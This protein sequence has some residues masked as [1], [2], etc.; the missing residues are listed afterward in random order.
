MEKAAQVVSRRVGAHSSDGIGHEAAVSRSVFSCE[1]HRLLDRGV[2]GEHGFDLTQLD[3]KAADFHLVVD[4]AEKLDVAVGQIASQI[5]GLVEAVLE[6]GT[7]WVGDELLRC[8]VRTIQVTPGQTVAANMQVSR[9]AD[10]DRLNCRS[11]I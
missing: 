9:Y 10:G 6:I 5:T 7:E 11:R 1:H 4:A 3:A 2:L 8:E